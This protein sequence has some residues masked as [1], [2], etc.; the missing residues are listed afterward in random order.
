MKVSSKIIAGFL[1]LMSLGVIVLV[2]E[3][4]VIHQMQTVNEELSD[5]NVYAA[6][7]VLDVQRLADLIDDDTRKYL[8]FLEPIYDKQ[9][10]ELR[11]DLQEDLKHLQQKVN[12]DREHDAIAKLGEAFESY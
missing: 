8:S 7:T 1:I 2:N 12:T 3:L 5:I 9:I 4:S 11:R 6:T 10:E